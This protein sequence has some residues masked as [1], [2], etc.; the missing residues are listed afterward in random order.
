MKIIKFIICNGCKVWYYDKDGG[1]IYHR[2]DGPA[3][4]YFKQQHRRKNFKVL[5]DWY[6][7]GCFVLPV[8]MPMNV[9]IAYCKWSLTNPHVI[10]N[11][12]YL[13]L[14]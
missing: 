5:C 10:K 7:N 12:Q 6:L 8:D 2:E 1:M 13:E 14:D 3:I 11:G 4:E 9:Y